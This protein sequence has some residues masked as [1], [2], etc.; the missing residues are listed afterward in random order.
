VKLGREV[1]RQDALYYS[2]ILEQDFVNE[3]GLIV[4]MLLRVAD[5]KPE[6]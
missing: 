2:K 5:K 6:M 3:T 1:E 4:K